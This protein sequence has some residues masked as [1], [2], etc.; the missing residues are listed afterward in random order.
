MFTSVDQ[1]AVDV[2]EY[3]QRH[4]GCPAYKVEDDVRLA[5]PDYYKD[6]AR[7]IALMC[8]DFGE[9]AIDP[10]VDILELIEQHPSVRRISTR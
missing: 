5:H 10:L 9:E 7:R 1:A 4:I 8:S 6:L 2:I 3:L